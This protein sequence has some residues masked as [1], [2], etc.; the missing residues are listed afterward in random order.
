MNKTAATR[1]TALK[2][3]LCSEFEF[4]LDV[5]RDDDYNTGCTA[6]THRT[7]AQGHDAKLAGFLVRAEMAGHDI[8]KREGGMLITYADAHDAAAKISD[9]LAVKV[10]LMMEAAKARAAKKAARQPTRKVT[11]AEIEQAVA[12]PTTRDAKIKVGRWEYDATIHLA[13][14]EATYVSKQGVS[15]TKK[16]GDFIEV[17]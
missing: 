9:A 13:T 7:F 14:G 17:N 4:D 5:E 10:D 8:S 11:K 16:A 2:R 3:C 15:W 6:M 12:E 1:K